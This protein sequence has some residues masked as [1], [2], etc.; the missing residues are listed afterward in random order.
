MFNLHYINSNTP[1]YYPKIKPKDLNIASWAKLRKQKIDIFY[2]TIIG[3][4]KKFEDSIRFYSIKEIFVDNKHFKKTKLYKNALIRIRNGYSIW[5][6]KTEDELN[7]R[8][9][10]ILP[11]LYESIKK[12][13]LLSQEQLNNN[14]SFLNDQ[15]HHSN[16][17]SI[18]DDIM[19]GINENSVYVF[20]DGS[21]RLAIAK[22]LGIH[23]IP[24]KIMFIH[25]HAINHKFSCDQEK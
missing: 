4:N 18:N 8:F 23:Q 20:L 10:Y 6:C 3:Q 11:R 22:I 19:I 21:H 1:V 16:K 14:A 12:Y 17:R 13:G 7:A 15:L 24:V 5:N 2:N 9:L 25:P